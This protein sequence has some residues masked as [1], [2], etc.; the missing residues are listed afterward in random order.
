MSKRLMSDAEIKR[1]KK[2][3]GHISQTTGALGLTSLAAFTASKT[4]GAKF[5]SKTPRLRRIA[6]A[7]DTKKAENIALGTS[8]AGAGIGGAGSFN[9]AAY[10]NAESRKRTQPV[11]KNDPFNIEKLGGPK[12]RLQSISYNDED[13]KGYVR[14]RD[15]DT[16][17]SHYKGKSLILRRPKYQ[18]VAAPSQKAGKNARAEISP[19][20]RMRKDAAKR[21]ADAYEA[22]SKKVTFSDG[23]TYKHRVGK[24]ANTSAFGVVHD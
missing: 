11:K 3:Q 4:P 1:R 19:N 20:F 8:T 7:V 22:K 14:H 18:V 21:I 24:S 16:M 15:P 6:S 2:L 13:S 10:T 17:V 23:S 5:M 12:V 9:F